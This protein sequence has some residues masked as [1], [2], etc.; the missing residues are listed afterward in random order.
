MAVNSGASLSGLAGEILREAVR[1]YDTDDIERLVVGYNPVL[2][3]WNTGMFAA[4]G[5]MTGSFRTVGFTS[6]ASGEPEVSLRKVFRLGKRLPAVRL[7]AA[8]ELAAQ[9]RSAPLMLRLEAL[10]SWLGQEGRPVTADDELP[11]DGAAEAARALGVSP[12][13]LPYLWDYALTARWVEFDDEPGGGWGTEGAGRAEGAGG[14]GGAGGVGGGRRGGARAVPGFTAWRW[15]GGDDVSTLRAWTVVFAAVLAQALE[16]AAALDPRGARKLR[17]EGQGVVVA[18]L[19]FLD[20]RTGMSAGGIRDVVRAGAL[21]GRKSARARR[22]WDAWI[23]EHGDPVRWLL[24]ELA[25]LRAVGAPA[26]DDGV[27]PLAPLAL[28]GLR[29]QLR[30]EGIEIPQIAMTGEPMRAADLVALAGSVSDAEFDAEAAAWVASR[31]P[32]RAARDLLAFAAFSGSQPRL[33]AVHLTRQIGPGANLAWRDA[34]QRPELRGYARV[35]LSALAAELPESTQPMVLDP[36]PDDLT[37][38]ATDLLTLAC[39]DED[40]D[41][42]EIAAQFAEAV[43]RGEESW[44]IG[45]M[46]RSSHPDVAQ[47]LT[48]LGRYHPDR[49]VAKEA[50]RA[51]R[52]VARN[53]PPARPDRVPARAAGR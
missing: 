52:A 17:F 31:G 18:M 8:A 14:A 43:P 2:A 40:P 22:P 10:A 50:R 49:R 47:V 20:R 32:D 29:E 13:Y 25:A 5:D 11:P 24:G 4:A 26:S 51:A 27:V 45:L 3:G 28:W 35:A 9:A 36:D 41:P 6:L 44:I 38:M 39:G 12:E 1:V 48:V 53:R 33:V 30:L 16:A 46:S 15:A 21:G 19:L 7:P 42:D 37:W 23:R 34:M